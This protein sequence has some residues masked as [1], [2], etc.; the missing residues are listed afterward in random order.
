ML[1]PV[2]TIVWHP[3]C[4]YNV[5]NKLQYRSRL[6]KHT[7]T[8]ATW[9]KH[10]NCSDATWWIQLK[11]TCTCTYGKV[12]VPVNTRTC[13][14]TW[15]CY[16]YLLLYIGTVAYTWPQPCPW[17]RSSELG[18]RPP[19]FEFLI[20][21]LEGSVISFISPSSGGS[22]GAVKPICAQKTLFISF[23]QLLNASSWGFME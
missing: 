9:V 12:P 18:L 19:G 4:F 17:P 8:V 21:C 23:R 2:I 6:Y 14:C 5:I 7:T 16:E 15:I 3:G 11:S 13:T 22:P 20:L 10:V 1:L